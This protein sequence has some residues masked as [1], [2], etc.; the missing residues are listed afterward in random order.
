[1]RTGGRRCF[2]ARRGRSG[3]TRRF[4]DQG[5]C[6]NAGEWRFIDAP[7]RGVYARNV[8]YRDVTGWESF[9]PWLTRIEEFEAQEA[10]KIAETIPPEWYGGDLAT[11]EQLVEKLMERRTRVRELILAFR[12]SSRAAVSKVGWDA[13]EKAGAGVR[14]GAAEWDDTLPGRVM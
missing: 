5:F 12:E 2:I 3:T 11:L 1:M 7:L 13:G 4:I 10:W 14:A 9:E 6:F 8:V